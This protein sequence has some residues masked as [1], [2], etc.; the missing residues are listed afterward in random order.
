M[1]LEKHDIR[2][3]ARL[4]RLHLTEQEEEI[5]QAELNHIFSLIQQIRSI[6]D[7]VVDG[8]KAPFF[9][10]LHSRFQLLKEDVVTETNQRELFQSVAPKVKDGFYIVPRVIE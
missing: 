6:D 10:H 5:I 3:L 1:G 9:Y 2:K 7:Q 8:P 4:V